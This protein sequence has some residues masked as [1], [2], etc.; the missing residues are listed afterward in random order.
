MVYIGTNWWF[1]SVH[2]S[3]LPDHE[4]CAEPHDHLSGKSSDIFRGIYYVN[5]YGR[6][7]GGGEGKD[8]DKGGG[9]KLKKLKRKRENSIKRLVKRIENSNKL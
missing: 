9:G 5:N 4:G 8:K 2:A 3:S 7:G 1:P 6:G